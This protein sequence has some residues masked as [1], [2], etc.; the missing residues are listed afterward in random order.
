MSTA[1]KEAE[2]EGKDYCNPYFARGDTKNKCIYSLEPNINT[3]KTALVPTAVTE[4]M[5]RHR[6]LDFD[7]HY[8][9]GA[10]PTLTQNS[11]YVDRVKLGPMSD[12][13]GSTHTPKV[14]FEGRHGMSVVYEKARVHLSHQHHCELNYTFL[15]SLYY[16]HPLVHNSPFLAHVGY[17][18]HGNNV[19]DASE[20]LYRA[21]RHEERDDLGEYNERC[22]ELVYQFSW[23]NPENQ[24][25]Y[26]SV[27]RWAANGYKGEI[28]NPSY[29][30]AQEQAYKYGPGTL[31][32]FPRFV[33]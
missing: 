19:F 5:H 8:I 32:P 10:A 3:V 31:A 11:K 20:M 7:K 22:E 17:Y 4:L 14:S 21:L 24:E 16:G 26:A 30:E 27:L 29:I 13:P 15:E 6:P 23:K 33:S 28:T 9:Y 25:G 18:Y 2:T 12:P 1:Q